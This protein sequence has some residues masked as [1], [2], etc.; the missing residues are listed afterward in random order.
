VNPWDSVATISVN[1]TEVPVKVLHATPRTQGWRDND[2]D[3]CE[4]GELVVLPAV[5]CSN[6]TADGPCGCARS[7]CGVSSG[8]ATTTAVVVDVPMSEEEWLAVVASA[9]VAD[10]WYDDSSEV[11]PVVFDDHRDLLAK[12]TVLPVGT[13]VE[14]RDDRLAVRPS[15]RRGAA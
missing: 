7:L 5:L 11:D 3:F 10:G 8:R 13:V 2:F 14:F 9:Y 6:E 15:T 12:I 4:D 1:V